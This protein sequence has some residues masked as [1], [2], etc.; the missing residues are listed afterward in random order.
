[1]PDS[2]KYFKRQVDGDLNVYFKNFRILDT[3]E[4]KKIIFQGQISE[5]HLVLHKLTK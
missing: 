5:V 2:T 3:Y 4:H 1:M